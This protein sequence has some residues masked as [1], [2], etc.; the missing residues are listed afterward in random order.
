VLTIRGP[1]KPA[2]IYVDA[3]IDSKSSEPRGS[4]SDSFL[5]LKIG[6]DKSVENDSS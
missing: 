4:L 3:G 1:I 2:T 5:W 6:E